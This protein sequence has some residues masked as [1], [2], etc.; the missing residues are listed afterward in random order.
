MAT[1]GEIEAILETGHFIKSTFNAAKK[2]FSATLDYF[3]KDPILDSKALIE[4]LDYL[5][6]QIYQKS[7]ETANDELKELNKK[8][9][10]VK[11]QIAELQF[12]HN[13]NYITEE[14]MFRYYLDAKNADVLSPK[15]R[16]QV[17]ARI[18]GL[19][20]SKNAEKEYPEIEYS[21]IEILKSEKF[22]QNEKDFALFGL[23]MK[24]NT[25][26]DV[27]SDNFDRIM[28]SSH[29]SP[30]MKGQAAIHLLHC[31]AQSS[32]TTI[33][34]FIYHSPRWLGFLEKAENISPI[35]QQYQDILKLQFANLNLRRNLYTHQGYENVNQA[36]FCFFQA[37]NN[38]GMHKKYKDLALDNLKLLKQPFLLKTEDATTL[39]TNLLQN[40][41]SEN[42]PQ[43]TKE[44]L[45]PLLIS[46]N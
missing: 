21:W 24:K 31:L 39:Y 2:T 35:R 27:D 19:Y 3:K 9:D 5:N 8:A 38:P 28:K 4:D 7:Y 26:W 33:W 20:F 41:Y 46:E 11:F 15:E 6:E 23:F 40:F 34:H 22:S 25:V 1:Q 16:L 43:S 13:A 29:L 17:A 45:R 10:Y 42:L 32:A 18:A 36:I 30:D 14:E 12:F 37:I 44:S